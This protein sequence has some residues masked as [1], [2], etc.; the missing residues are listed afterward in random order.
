MEDRNPSSGGRIL[1]I[2]L[3][4]CNLAMLVWIVLSWRGE[5]EPKSAL[6]YY[7]DK[8]YDV[9]MFETEENGG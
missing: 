4:L 9:S 7:R 8:G 1:N 5:L 3:V 2:I 6:D